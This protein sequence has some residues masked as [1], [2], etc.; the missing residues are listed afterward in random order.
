M[1]NYRSTEKELLDDFSLSGRD[2]EKNLIN[3]DKIN[4]LLGGN[5]IVFKSVK[6]IISRQTPL[7]RKILRV[8]DLGCG[9]GSLLRTLALRTKEISAQWQFIGVDANPAIIQWAIS[10]SNKFGN[11]RYQPINI[12]SDEFRSE[13]F[14]IILLNNVCHHFSNTELVHLFKQ[15]KTQAKAAIIVND[16]HRHWLA[17]LGIKLLTTIFP[18]SHL[19]KHDGPLSVRKAFKRTELKYL[20]QQ[21]DISCYQLK[22]RWAFRYQVLIYL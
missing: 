19:E 1:L 20:L 6:K 18:C 4:R 21:A 13:K 14:D 7:S 5:S 10:L 17:Y 3:L 8:A 22:W 12:F 9:S 16:L 11:I 15:L 2:L